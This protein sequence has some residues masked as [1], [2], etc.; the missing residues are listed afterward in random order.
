MQGE[1]A[2]VKGKIT[3]TGVGWLGVGTW[4]CE[5]REMT[6]LRGKSV[7]DTGVGWLRVEPAL[8]CRERWRVSGGETFL[9][10][11]KGWGGWGLNL[12][13]SAGRNDH[14]R[15]GDLRIWGQATHSRA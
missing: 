15:G 6:V 1:T 10:K 7:R 13:L 12:G 5:Q 3:I 14:G 4:V 11:K 9:T 8:L 2:I